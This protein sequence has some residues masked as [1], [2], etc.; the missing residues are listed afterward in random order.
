MQDT[1]N[2]KW[3]ELE[4]REIISLISC[5]ICVLAALQTM[6]VPMVPL[7]QFSGSSAN[8]VCAK[9]AFPL[10]TKIKCVTYRSFNLNYKLHTLV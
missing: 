10:P 6:E 2:A 5:L 3:K 1:T 7:T 8:E 9:I 4:S